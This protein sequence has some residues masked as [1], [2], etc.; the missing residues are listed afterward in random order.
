[1]TDDLLQ[2]ADND[3]QESRAVEGKPYVRCSGVARVLRAL[4]QRYVMGP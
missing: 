3:Q 1:L 4:V 2:S